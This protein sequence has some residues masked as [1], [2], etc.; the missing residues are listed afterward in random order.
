MFTTLL[1]EVGRGKRG[2][3]DL[4]YDEALVAADWIYSRKATPAQIGAFFIAQRIKTESVEELEAFVTV[5]RQRAHR[6]P[7]AGGIDCAGPYDGRIKS[8]YATFATS[9][10]LAAAGLPV[11]LHS[12]PALP[13]K[14]GVTLHALLDEIGIDEGNFTP[15]RAAEIA[16]QTGI[17]HVAAEQWCPPLAALRPIRE[18]LHMRTILNTVEKL[19]DYS[20]SP[21][22]VI[23]VFHNTVFDRLSVLLNRLGYRK[24][25]IVQGVEGSEDVFIDRPTRTCFVEGDQA[26]FQRIDPAQYGLAA[27]LPDNVTW[28]PAEQ[29]RITEE[30]LQGKGHVGYYHQVLLNGAI[31]LHLA[32]RANTIEQGLSVCRS[33]VEN[34]DAWERYSEWKRIVRS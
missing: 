5:C 2:A 11:T 29:I 34:G 23:G 20:H 8:F 15:Q 17:L 24:S 1:K 18:E 14:Q 12:I 25:L 30:V 13:P 26:T 27:P 7:I 28:T 16:A 33:L 21:Y 9:F 4:S 22:L 3:R 31:R 6:A 32:G 10:L 19:I